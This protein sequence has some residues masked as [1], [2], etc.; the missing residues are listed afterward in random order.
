MHMHRYART[1]TCTH[2]RTHTHTH[3]CACAH[4]HTHTYT[5]IHTHT[6]IEAPA[7]TKHSDY[8]KLIL[9]SLKRAANGD[10]IAAVMA[11]TRS[12]ENMNVCV[13]SVDL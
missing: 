1:R 10:V 12:L 13:A 2:A 4:T 9:H 3:R 7:H 8:T 11:E 6:V 5:H